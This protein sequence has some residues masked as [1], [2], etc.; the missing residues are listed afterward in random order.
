MPR[1][2]AVA[3]AVFALGAGALGEVIGL[4]AVFFWVLVVLMVV[5]G[6]FCG[7]LHRTYPADV[8]AVRQEPAARNAR[9]SL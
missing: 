9:S 3:Y 7:L 8:R 2:S 5:D 4:K 6:A 1:R